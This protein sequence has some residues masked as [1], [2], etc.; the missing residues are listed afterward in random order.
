MIKVI[1]T[2]K[3]P[4]RSIGR[5]SLTTLRSA[6]FWPQWMRVAN[7]LTA[8]SLSPSILVLSLAVKQLATTT[9]TAVSNDRTNELSRSE[10]SRTTRITYTVRSC[11]RIRLPTMPVARAMI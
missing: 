1:P 9:Y 8:A 10:L 5:R 3:W 4:E 2:A 11:H 7:L 6:G